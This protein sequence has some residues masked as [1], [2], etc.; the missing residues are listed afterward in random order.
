MSKRE[1]LTPLHCAGRTNS[2]IIKVTMLWKNLRSLVHL[3]IV[4]GVEDC[5]V[6]SKKV[7]KAI[8]ECNAWQMFKDMN[9][10]VTSMRT[11]IKN[12][13]KLLPYKIKRDNTPHL[14]KSK[15]KRRLDR[16]KIKDFKA[17][18]TKRKIVFFFWWTN[19]HN[20][21]FC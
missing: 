11:V 1:A 9:V 17:N 12:D 4:L 14:S 19:L 5:T 16:A 15:K 2:E 13:L 8:Q 21:S 7:I 20:W 6:W 10:S 3:M 18:T